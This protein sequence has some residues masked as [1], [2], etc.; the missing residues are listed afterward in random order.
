MKGLVYDR[1][2]ATIRDDV[3]VRA[4]GP[5]DVEVRIGAAGSRGTEA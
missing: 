1:S 4:P 3:E 5:T 2:K